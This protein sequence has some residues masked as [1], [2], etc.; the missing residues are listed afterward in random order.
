MPGSPA[1]ARILDLERTPLGNVWVGMARGIA[2]F[3]GGAA[4]SIT[5]PGSGFGSDQLASAVCVL[6]NED[7]IVGTGSGKAYVYFRASATFSTA[8]AVTDQDGLARVIA[9]A[10]GVVGSYIVSATISGTNTSAEFH[11]TN[12]LRQVFVPLLRT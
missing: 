4:S 10:N 12:R 6:D 9:T 3:E 8:S 1:D 11:L 5:L 2:Y 7:V